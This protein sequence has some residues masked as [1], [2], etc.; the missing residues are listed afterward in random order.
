MK[1]NDVLQDTHN[2]SLHCS[3]CSINNIQLGHNL[4][5]GTFGTLEYWT[6]IFSQLLRISW[7]CDACVGLRC[8]SPQLWSKVQAS[9]QNQQNTKLIPLNLEQLLHRT[10]GDFAEYLLHKTPHVGQFL[11][12]GSLWRLFNF[13]LC[14]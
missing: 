8:P 13:S 1:Q 6:V 12:D 11:H 9:K 10:I 2:T 7:T 4:K 14:L 5:E 3:A